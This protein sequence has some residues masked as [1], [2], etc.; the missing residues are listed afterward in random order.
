MCF[1]MFC[2]FVYKFSYLKKIYTAIIIHVHRSL[3][4]VPVILLRFL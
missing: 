2:K 3:Y 4:K 1:E